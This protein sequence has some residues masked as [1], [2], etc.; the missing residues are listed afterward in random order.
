MF[1][2]ASEGE[3]VADPLVGLLGRFFPTRSRI[4]LIRAASLNFGEEFTDGAGEF[5]GEQT[6]TGIGGFASGTPPSSN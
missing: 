2:E 1:G 3:D 4:L 5:G 6:S